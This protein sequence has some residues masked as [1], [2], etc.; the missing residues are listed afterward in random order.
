M[1]N[2]RYYFSAI[3]AFSIWGVFSLALRPIKEFAPLDILFYRISL[4]LIL[5][6]ILVFAIRRKQLNETLRTFSAFDKTKK[7][8]L[9]SINV[10]AGLLL[11]SNWFLFIYVM[12]FVSVKATA[13]SYLVCPILTAALAVIILKEKMKNI[14][15]IALLVGCAGCGMLAAGHLRDLVLSVLIG[16]SY[17][18]YLIIQKKNAGF[19]SFCILTFHVCVAVA[20]LGILFP[21][22]DIGVP[23]SPKFYGFIAI[24]AVCFTILPMFLSLLALKGIKSSTVGMLMNINPII[25]FALSVFYFD[26]KADAWQYSAYS[27]VFV[28]VILFNIPAILGKRNTEPATAE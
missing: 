19:D 12:N 7:R 3:S 4:C 8:K 13:L 23:Q 20:T 27:I 28:S 18:L 16:V 21:F 25:S 26:E 22:L 24:I 11:T 1:N 10:V 6:L 5:L 14:Q 9:L 15:W 2:S 17:A